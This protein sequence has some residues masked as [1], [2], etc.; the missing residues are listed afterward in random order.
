MGTRRGGRLEAAGGSGATAIPI[1][2]PVT[3][4]QEAG[5]E[6]ELDTPAVTH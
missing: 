2:V 5:D 4:L 1:V 6:K 3:R